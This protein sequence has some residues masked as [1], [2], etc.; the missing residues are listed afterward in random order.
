MKPFRFDD[1]RQERIYRQL[2]L[3]GG[4]PASFY[5]DACQLMAGKPLLDST[6][7]LVA[8][9]VRDIESA[10]RDVLEPLADRSAHPM[11]TDVS[12]SKGNSHS[13]EIRAVL[14]ALEIPETNPVAQAWLVLP[15]KNNTHGLAARAHR[16]ALANPRL[17]DGEF[18]QFW[19]KMEDILDIILEKFES[20]YLDSHHLLDELLAKD[21]PT[22]KDAE[23]LLSK[24]IGNNLKGH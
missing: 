14:K 11:R 2:L 24:I 6:T 13:A 12:T 5:R 9:L 8:H 3:V 10:L 23:P 7:H 16:D 20:R 17:L 1:P 21:S 19:A 4:G 22:K 15:G 18:R